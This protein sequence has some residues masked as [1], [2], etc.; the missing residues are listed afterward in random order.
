MMPREIM[1]ANSL[2]LFPTVALTRE[3]DRAGGWV[4]DDPT[5]CPAIFAV[6]EDAYA[7]PAVLGVKNKAVAPAPFVT[8]TCGNGRGAQM[9]AAPRETEDRTHVIASFAGPWM[10]GA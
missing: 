8:K 5:R 3:H 2:I 7:R 9:P 6:A 10:V 1:S 4:C